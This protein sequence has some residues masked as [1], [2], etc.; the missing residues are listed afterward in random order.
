[1][2]GVQNGF[3]CG[4]CHTSVL[5]ENYAKHS[6]SQGHVNNTL[7]NQCTNSMIKKTRHKKR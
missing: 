4:V 5:P 6:R 1:M 2:Y 3:F 7:R